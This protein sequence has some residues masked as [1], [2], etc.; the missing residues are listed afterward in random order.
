MTG[1]DPPA[2]VDH[3]DGDRLNNS[4]NNL[5]LANKSENMANRVPP[6]NNTSGFKGVSYSRSRRKYE[7]HIMKNR[8]R[9]FLGRFTTLSEAAAAYEVAALELHQQFKN[10]RTLK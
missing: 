10:T 4:W 7:V 6:K 2:L 5:R 1:E 9:Q 3:I 8:R